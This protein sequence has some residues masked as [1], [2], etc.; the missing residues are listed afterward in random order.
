MTLP[1]IKPSKLEDLVHTVPSKR[2][3]VVCMVSDK[4]SESRPGMKMVRWA[5]SKMWK[6]EKKALVEK[7]QKRN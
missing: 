4:Y 7:E 3:L 5:A 2:L 1:I 6:R